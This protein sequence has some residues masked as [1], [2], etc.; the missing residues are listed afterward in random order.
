MTA[1]A[2]TPVTAHA[3]PDVSTPAAAYT[4]VS[5]SALAADLLESAEPRAVHAGAA[6]LND[7]ARPYEPERQ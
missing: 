3:A 5:H 6:L 7:L 2:S 4:G 1:V